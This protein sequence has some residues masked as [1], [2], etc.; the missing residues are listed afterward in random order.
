VVGTDEDVGDSLTY[1]LVSGPAG[2]MIDPLSG[3]MCWTPTNDDSGNT[4]AVIVMVTDSCGAA[5]TTSFTITVTGTNDPPTLAPIGDQTASEDMPFMMVVTAEDMDGNTLTFSD[6]CALFVID[7]ATG[8]I[9]FTPANGDVGTYEVTVNVSDGTAST[10]RTFVLTVLNVNDPPV[11]GAVSGG[12]VNESAQFTTTALANDQDAGDT[13]TYYL[14]GAPAGMVI[15]PHTGVISWT[16][17]AGGIYAVYVVAEDSTGANDMRSF[18]VTVV[19]SAIPAAPNADPTL[20]AVTAS[21]SNAV[22][23]DYRF[24]VLYKDAD[25]DA[26]ADLVMILDGTEYTL[27]ATQSGSYVSGVMYEMTVNLSAGQHVYYF[28][29]DDGQGNTAIT[30]PMSLSLSEEE[31]DSTG[32]A[33]SAG[34]E[35]ASSSDTLWLI[36]ILLLLAIMVLLTALMVWRIRPREPEMYPEDADFEAMEESP[37]EPAD[38]PELEDVPEPIEEPVNQPEWNE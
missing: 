25:G 27:T 23:G 2:M 13:I 37:V 1:S 19:A 28:L 11:L 24:A 22:E 21:D 26:P 12:T 5:V 20:E 17:S 9:S 36:P 14:V 31:V 38:A 33:A 6:D 29:A 8:V 18:T 30:V 4:Y 34:Q 16:P 3:A 7:P 15:D 35:A 10:A 32:Q